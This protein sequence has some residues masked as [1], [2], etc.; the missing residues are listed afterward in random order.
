MRASSSGANITP[1]AT[2]GAADS[3]TTSIAGGAG[4]GNTGECGE[5]EGA[6]SGPSSIKAKSS[7]LADTEVEIGE[8]ESRMCSIMKT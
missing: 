6:K 1:R 7:E 5:G 3:I 4:V 8:S 2:A